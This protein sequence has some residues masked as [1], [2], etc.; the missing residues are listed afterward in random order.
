MN[1]S[2]EVI[3]NRR[4]PTPVEDRLFA[5]YI[6]RFMGPRLETAVSPVDAKHILLLLDAYVVIVALRKQV[7]QL[8]EGSVTPPSP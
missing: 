7:Q 1:L 6:E 4:D 3:I 8:Q 5:A 2:D